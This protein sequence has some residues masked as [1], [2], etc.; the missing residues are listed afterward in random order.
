MSVPVAA[1]IEPDSLPNLATNLDEP[2]CGNPATR[3]AYSRGVA[4]AINTLAARAP[5]VTLYLDAGIQA[6]ARSLD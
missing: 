2:R 3:T 5:H 4:Y 1:V 6:V